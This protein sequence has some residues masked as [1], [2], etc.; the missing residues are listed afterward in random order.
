MET[1]NMKS[2]YLLPFA[3]LV[4]LAAC[5]SVPTSSSS[6]SSGSPPPGSSGSSS[7]SSPPPGSSQGN[8]GSQSPQSGQQSGPGSQQSASN[9]GSEQGSQSGTGQQ[10]GNENAAGQGEKSEDEIL[11][12]ALGELEKGFEGSEQGSAESGRTGAPGGAGGSAQKAMTD[13]EKARILEAQLGDKFAKFDE[14]MLGEREQIGREGNEN[15]SGGGDYGD[16]DG[17]G[18]GDDPLQTAMAEPPP[19]PGGGVG[20]N[21]PGDKSGG[22]DVSPAPPDIDDGKD[23]D[24]IARQLRE[25]AQKEKDPEL[26]AKLWDEYRKYKKGV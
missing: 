22:P 18:D 10:A 7:S 11:A 16:L 12:D 6:S 2:S 4:C 9:D 3:L 20:R 19:M 14:Q 15:G 26:R 25:A 17:D 21:F 23:D 5:N 1:I 24:I 8:P 13:E